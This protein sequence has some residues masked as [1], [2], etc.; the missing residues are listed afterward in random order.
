MCSSVGGRW[1]GVY[2]PQ[3]RRA[4]TRCFPSFTRSAYCVWQF[5]AS[6][7]EDDLARP[8]L[9]LVRRPGDQDGE[10]MTA[11]WWLGIAARWVGQ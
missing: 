1:R 5:V 6:D 7:S 2:D 10:T 8:V 9:D 3:R 4:L 11:A